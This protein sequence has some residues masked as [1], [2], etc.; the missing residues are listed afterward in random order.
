MRSLSRSVCPQT[1]EGR[2]R[3]SHQA[4]PRTWQGRE[5]YETRL[6]TVRHQGR[7]RD[8]Q[9]TRGARVTYRDLVKEYARLNRPETTYRRVPSG[10]YINFLSDFM[11]ANP[12]ATMAAAIR[13]W[14]TVKSMNAPKN[15][16]TFART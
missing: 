11:A 6:V 7:W 16:R 1:A 9:L 10:R 8:A 14:K 4:L 5:P 12:G 13:A 15:Y 2:A 3:E